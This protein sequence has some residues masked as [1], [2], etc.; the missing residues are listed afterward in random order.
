MYL[1]LPAGVVV[2]VAVPAGDVVCVTL[3]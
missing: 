2:G 1:Y 3:V